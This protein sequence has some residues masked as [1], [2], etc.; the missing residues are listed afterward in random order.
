VRSAADGSASVSEN[1]SS[2]A[3]WK[4]VFEIRGDYIEKTPGGVKATP[5][6]Q[7]QFNAL[8]AQSKVN[9]RTLGERILAF[10]RQAAVEQYV[11]NKGAALSGV[12]S[13]IEKELDRLIDEHRKIAFDQ[14]I[15]VS[16]SYQERVLMK[17]A[18]TVAAEDN[19]VGEARQLQQEMDDLYQRARRG[20]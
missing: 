3:V 12:K 10:R 15:Q 13:G 8:M 1:H 7:Q 2:D 19:N 20:Y 17:N 9:G 4:A 6:E 14:L 18:I 5:A 16:P 11:Q